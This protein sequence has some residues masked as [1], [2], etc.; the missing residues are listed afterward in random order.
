MILGRWAE[1]FK[2]V[3]NRP[4]TIKDEA[5]DRLPQIT[6]NQEM[7]ELPTREEIERAIRL[8]S[9]GKAPGSD[10]IPAGIY[11]EGGRTL[12]GKLHQLFHLIGQE[13]VL[14]QD[15]KDA[16]IIHLY[17]RKGN[18]QVCDNHWGLSLLSTAGK[19]L[20]RVLL[21]RLIVHLEKDLLPESRSG[22]RKDRGTI[23]MV[24]AARQLQEK[25]QEQNGDLYSTYIDLTKEYKNWGDL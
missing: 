20:V 2:F 16:S 4:S 13:E 25:C 7:D 5:I 14:P 15:F 11:E 23:D 17:K 8:F 22:F 24:F 18:R 6:V 21:N 9:T 12:T 1:H 3:L 10:S 19:V